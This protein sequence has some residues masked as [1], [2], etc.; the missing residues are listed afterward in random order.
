MV[1]YLSVCGLK[2]TIHLRLLRLN[3]GGGVVDSP[4]SEGILP[5]VNY[6]LIRTMPKTINEFIQM[7]SI[8]F[9]NF[10]I[11]WQF[12]HGDHILIYSK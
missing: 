11:S 1:N 3:G 8:T 9:S 5:G 12:Y 6:V 10:Y 7:A 4:S 2:R